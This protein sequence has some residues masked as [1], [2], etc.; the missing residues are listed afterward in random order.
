MGIGLYL[1]DYKAE[2]RQQWGQDRQFGVMAQEVEM[3]MSEA[4]C[5]HLD[6]CKMVN[7]SMLGIKQTVH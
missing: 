1:F 6:G 7:H 3:S 2:Y 4:V 5:V